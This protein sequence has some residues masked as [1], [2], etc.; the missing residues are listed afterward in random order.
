MRLSSSSPAGAFEIPSKERFYG[1]TVQRRLKHPTVLAISESAQGEVCQESSNRQSVDSICPFPLSLSC[2]VFNPYGERLTISN[3]PERLVMKDA[4]FDLV[5][6]WIVN[7]LT[8]F[9][10]SGLNVLRGGWTILNSWQAVDKWLS[11]LVMPP[12]GWAGA[13]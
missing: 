3:Q 12:P 2:L 1:M 10:E 8:A 5:V 13:G 4:T 9:A 11:A 7:T 6:S